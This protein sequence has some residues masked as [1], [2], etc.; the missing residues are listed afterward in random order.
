MIPIYYLY[1]HMDIHITHGLFLFSYP[2]YSGPWIFSGLSPKKCS[3]FRVCMQVDEL[4]EFAQLIPSRERSH[5][6]PKGKRKIIL[7]SAG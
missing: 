5:I 3:Y 6:P 2:N 1:I 7:K 4:F